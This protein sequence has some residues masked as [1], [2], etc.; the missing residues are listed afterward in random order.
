MFGVNIVA[1]LDSPPEALAIQ[2][3]DPGAR[4]NDDRVGGRRPGGPLKR[5]P[6]V[7]VA[8]R[9]RLDDLAT[10]PNRSVSSSRGVKLVSEGNKRCSVDRRTTSNANDD[11]NHAVNE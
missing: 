9:D 6:S 5:D 8:R 11:T 1:R 2:D 7:G 3:C 4:W 10:A